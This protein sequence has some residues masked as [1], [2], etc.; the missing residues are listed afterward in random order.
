MDKLTEVHTMK[1]YSVIKSNEVSHHKK[2]KKHE[3]TL[4]AYCYVK[5]ASLK[6]FHII[7]L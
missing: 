6:I 2:K 1:Y 3:G 4:K 7:W 5:E